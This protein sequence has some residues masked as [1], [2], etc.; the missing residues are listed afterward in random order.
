MK[1]ITRSHLKHYS[2]RQL[3]TLFTAIYD[4]L[5]KSD[6]HSYER[7]NALASLENIQSEIAQRDHYF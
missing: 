1:L 3:R 5:I 2:K 7:R 4:E 6:Q